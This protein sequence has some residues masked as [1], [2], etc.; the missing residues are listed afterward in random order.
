MIGIMPRGN[1]RVFLVGVFVYTWPSKNMTYS[2]LNSDSL[3]IY[4]CR[5]N[6]TPL[7]DLIRH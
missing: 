7:L 4:E 1:L 6:V 5:R 3:P 2:L